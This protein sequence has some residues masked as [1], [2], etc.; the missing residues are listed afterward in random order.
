MSLRST[1]AVQAALLSALGALAVAYPLLL[2]TEPADDLMLGA[3]TASVAAAAA[4][5]PLWYL[6]FPNQKASPRRG[7]WIGPLVVFSAMWGMFAVFGLTGDAAYLGN[8]GM[9]AVAAKSVFMGAFFAVFGILYTG[10]VLLPLSMAVAVS[11]RKW[12]AG[13]GPKARQG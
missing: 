6:A 3:V 11:F 4:A 5:L 9:G 12:Q 8:E 2:I 10:I 1:H 7:L 13:K